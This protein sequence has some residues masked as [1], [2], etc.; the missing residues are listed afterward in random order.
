MS[1]RILLADDHRILREGL[2]SLLEREVDLEVVAEAGNGREAV[3]LARELSPDVAVVDISMPD[4]NGIEA[5]RRMLSEG[6]GTRVIALSVHSHRRFIVEMLRAGAFGYL[7]KD[8]ATKEL[9]GAVRAVAA[10]GTYLSPAIAGVVAEG[11]V[12][13]SRSQPRLAFDV[14][15]GREREVLQLLAEGKNA[16]QIAH[17]LGL[18]ASTIAVHRKNIMDKLDIHNLAELTKYAVRE[19]LT[20]LDD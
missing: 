14:L 20:S 11:F 16:K 7:L 6:S 1:I 8:C 2:R 3:R 4:L 19:G 15:S 5:T 9:V 18:S 13:R 12:D 10:G 17:E